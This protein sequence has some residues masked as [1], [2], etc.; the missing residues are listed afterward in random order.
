MKYVKIQDYYAREK[1]I[2]IEK[3][4]ELK[5]DIPIDYEEPGYIEDSYFDIEGYT[6]Q[7]G[8]E[9]LGIFFPRDI[10]AGTIY[11]DLSPIT[12]L[13]REE[14][15]QKARD[16]LERRKQEEAFREAEREKL[17]EEIS[18]DPLVKALIQEFEEAGDSWIKTNNRWKGFL[19]IA[20]A[21]F[22]KSF[23][24]WYSKVNYGNTNG[25]C[26]V[27]YI[28]IIDIYDEAVTTAW[29]I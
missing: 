23:T 26:N 29:V 8:D 4:L 20:K 24:T 28:T 27:V 1:C 12:D 17:Q 21:K 19:N 16:E 25:L 14:A 11:A 5:G 7:S 6:P 15:Y 13:D 22:E 3:F 10:L 2:N 18:N 9:C